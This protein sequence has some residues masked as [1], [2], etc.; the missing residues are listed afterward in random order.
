MKTISELFFGSTRARHA[1]LFG[2]EV[3]VESNTHLNMLTD[4]HSNYW[5]RVDEGS[6]RN[7]TEYIFQRP[8]NTKDK[9][10]ALTEL[11]T[12]L[13]TVPNLDWNSKRTSVHVHINMLKNTPLDVYKYLTAYGLLEEVMLAFCTEGR[14]GNLFCLSMNNAEFLVEALRDDITS[15]STLANLV[16]GDNLR[17][18]SV[19]VSSIGK[20]GSVEFRTLQGGASQQD[21]KL[22]SDQLAKIKSGAMTFEH[23]QA[24]MD[25]YFL[26]SPNTFL[27]VFCTS[28]FKTRLKKIKGW[29]SKLEENLGIITHFAYAVDWKVWMARIESR[30]NSIKNIKRLRPM[31]GRPGHGPDGTPDWAARR[32][33][34]LRERA[35]E[36]MLDPPTWIE[37]AELE[38]QIRPPAPP[39]LPP[40]G[41]RG[42]RRQRG[43]GM[44]EPRPIR[45]RGEYTINTTDTTAG[46]VDWGASEVTIRGE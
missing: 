38:E 18:S 19:N 43:G 17:Y 9:D 3:E 46:P 2:I 33:D 13:K 24:I 30:D 7:G 15:Y 44:R 22:W 21:V 5:M 25:F 6:V 34:E 37:E 45:P 35:T 41:P 12:Y 29:Q 32:M 27:D 36:G 4:F 20:F 26:A 16:H 28:R 14:E 42:P 40:D 1:G 11:Y 23:P 10:A 8:L 39:V 31:R